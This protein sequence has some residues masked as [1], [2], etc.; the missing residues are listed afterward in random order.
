MNL[1]RNRN[2]FFSLVLSS[3]WTA[4]ANLCYQAWCDDLLMRAKTLFY[5]SNINTMQQYSWNTAFLNYLLVNIYIFCL[6]IGLV[7]SI[8]LT[9]KGSL[10]PFIFTIQEGC[11]RKF[12]HFVFSFIWTTLVN[13]WCCNQAWSCNDLLMKQKNS[14]LFIWNQY[15]LTIRLKHSLLFLII[16]KLNLT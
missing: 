2:S 8:I 5:S 10:C 1:F 11:W 14:A 12:F 4:L 16:D 7:F 15:H 6:F 13:L 3:I 9:S